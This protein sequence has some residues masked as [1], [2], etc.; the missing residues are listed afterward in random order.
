MRA[1][2]CAIFAALHLAAV[3][4]AAALPLCRGADGHE[5]FEIGGD[6]CCGAGVGNPAPEE[7]VQALGENL[8]CGGCLDTL[9]HLSSGMQVDLAPG[10]FD[11]PAGA[12]VT[13]NEGLAPAMPTART[14][15]ASRRPADVPPRC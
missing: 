1:Y 12:A 3:M 13:A 9:S 6:D 11:I 15:P 14:S 7:P 10:A 5:A 2:S 4:A 8:E